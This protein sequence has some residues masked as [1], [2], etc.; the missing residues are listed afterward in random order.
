[1]PLKSSLVTL[2]SI[3]TKALLLYDNPPQVLLS[4]MLLKKDYNWK[5]IFNFPFPKSCKLP[6]EAGSVLPSLMPPDCTK[7]KWR[8]VRIA[9]T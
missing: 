5:R 7:S 8:K 2:M 4:F 9:H 1:M 3:M 6:K